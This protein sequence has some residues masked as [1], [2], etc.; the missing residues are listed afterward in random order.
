MTMPNINPLIAKIDEILYVVDDG[1]YD[2]PDLWK[3]KNNT[4]K[5]ELKELKNMMK[6]PKEH[7]I[8]YLFCKPSC[9]GCERL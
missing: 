1:D 7:D 9:K 5:S 2:M 6:N 8:D 3:L 4:L